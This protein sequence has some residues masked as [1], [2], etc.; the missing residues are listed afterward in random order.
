MKTIRIMS[1]GGETS[2]A[3]GHVVKDIANGSISVVNDKGEVL[4]NW[5][6][7]VYISETDIE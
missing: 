4:I 3:V 5:E 1:I 6:N 2:V 7:I